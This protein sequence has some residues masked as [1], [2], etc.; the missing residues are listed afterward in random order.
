M[1]GEDCH[2]IKF[3]GS[4]PVP[5]PSLT[6]ARDI[7]GQSESPLR[8]GGCV[9]VRKRTVQ[10]RVSMCKGPEVEGAYLGTRTSLW[11]P[12]QV[13]CAWERPQRLH[14]KQELSPGRAEIKDD[15]S[16]LF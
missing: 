14:G 15:G 6:R 1:H 12:V 16:R 13:N 10:L 5:R 2:A 3:K 7:C 9:C 8:L 4:L 11:W